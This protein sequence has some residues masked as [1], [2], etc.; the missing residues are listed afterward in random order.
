MDDPFPW[1]FSFSAILFSDFYFIA[2]NGIALIALLIFSALVSGSEV[3]YFSLSPKEIENCNAGESTI[4]K[5]MS[6]LLK[7][8]KRLLATILILNNF[9]NIT[10]IML[11]TYIAVAI[12]NTRDSEGT[13]LIALTVIITLII[14]FFGEIVPKVYATHNNLKFAKFTSGLLKVS[15]NVFKPIAWVLTS[16]SNVVEK[17][18]EKKGYNISV[19]EMHQVLELTTNKESTE[20][21]KDLLKGIVN[22]GTLSVKQIMKS[23]LDITAI[24]NQSAYKDVL[25]QIKESGFSRVP[26][27]NETIDSIEGI[28]YIKDL[29][30]HLDEENDFDWKFLM[31]PVFFVPEQK[32]I[33]TLFKDFQ[34]RRVHI[35]IVV[36]EYGGTSGL[37]TME[38]VIEEIVGEINDEF[39]NDSDVS[40]KKVNANTYIFEGKTSL[41]DFYKITDVAVSTFDEVKGESES[42]G[43]LLLELSS[44]LMKVGEEIDYEGFTFTI[45][46][47]DKKSIKKVKV[48]IK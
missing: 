42:L 6:I 27:Y 33:D 30:P 21:E 22:F 47:A 16:I 7:E 46:D 25:K 39:D 20:E 10:I 40:F 18:I 5:R 12:N 26:V 31:K 36:D 11:S 28:L 3:A 41:M 34:E 8:P 4:Q 17:R 44:K 29:L 19:D 48:L 37:I 23:R 15:Y 35:A 1:F 38:D 32:K 43:G 14:V 2:I 24:E 45:M 13:I 9:I